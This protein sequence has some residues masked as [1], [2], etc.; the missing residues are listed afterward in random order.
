MCVRAYQLV[1]YIHLFVIT[2]ILALIILWNII[3]FTWLWYRTFIFLLFVYFRQS[4]AYTGK[5]H[6]QLILSAAI[7]RAYITVILIRIRLTVIFVVFR[8]YD[9]RGI[10]AVI[11]IGLFLRLCVFVWCTTI[12]TLLALVIVVIFELKLLPELSLKCT[13]HLFTSQLRFS[14][15]FL[16]L[17][18]CIYHLSHWTKPTSLTSRSVAGMTAS[19]LK[20]SK[21]RRKLRRSRRW[22]CCCACCESV[23]EGMVVMMISSNISASVA[24]WV[25]VRLLMIAKHTRKVLHH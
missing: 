13:K 12:K 15:L 16:F 14:V 3:L 22:A 5:R 10:T 23:T 19:T 7:L 4:T 9:L 21:L 6:W 25:S 1:S 2:L 17:V 24:L 20:W 18:V 8:C 11:S